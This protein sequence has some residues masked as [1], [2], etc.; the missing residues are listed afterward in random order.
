MKKRFL[1]SLILA[2]V[3]VLFHSCHS[4]PNSAAERTNDGVYT[5]SGSWG[6]VELVIMGD[7]WRSTIDGLAGTTYSS[8]VI[9]ADN[10]YA[11]PRSSFESQRLVGHIDGSGAVYYLN[12][13]MNK[14]ER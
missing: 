6:H 3:I 9:Q 8:G 4:G 13:K 11:V 7:M 14:R 2:T 10:L 1:F 5:A 12:K